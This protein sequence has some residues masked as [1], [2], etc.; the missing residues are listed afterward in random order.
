MP[1]TE[2]PKVYDPKSVESY[3]ADVWIKERIFQPQLNQ[4]TPF[5]IVIQM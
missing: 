3:W 5:V 2:I 1:I 4:K